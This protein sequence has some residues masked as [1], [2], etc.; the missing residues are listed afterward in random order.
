[1]KK[2]FVFIETLTV[3]TIL[4]T[5]IL[6]IFLTYQ[7]LVTNVQKRL[8]YDN[9]SDIYKTDILRSKI[10]RDVIKSATGSVVKI[11][12]SNCATYMSGSCN[13]L[14]TDLNT[15][16]IFINLVKISEVT[17]NEFNN[18]FNDYI[19]TIEKSSSDE[20][21][22]R[23]ETYNRAIIVNYNYNNHNYYASLNI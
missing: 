19:K 13:E 4:V 11:D 9:I 10:K 18:T 15:T 17:D 23:T 3:L 21:G 1:M 14:M 5:T 20:S 7:A 16:A 22:F 6:S 12:R 8:Y 2:G